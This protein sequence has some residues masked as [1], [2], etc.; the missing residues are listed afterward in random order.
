MVLTPHFWQ[1]VDNLSIES[2]WK[3]HLCYNFTWFHFVLRRLCMQGKMVKIH[4]NKASRRAKAHMVPHGVARRPT[5]P[6]HVTNP[7]ET[8]K[9]HQGAMWHVDFEGGLYQWTWWSQVGTTMDPWAHPSVQTNSTCSKQHNFIVMDKWGHIWTVEK[10]RRWNPS[11][12]RPNCA[13][14]D[15][16]KCSNRLTPSNCL[17]GASLAVDAPR[18]CIQA[19]PDAQVG[20]PTPFDAPPTFTPRHYK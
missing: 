11:V 13:S 7:W 8:K 15:V 6:C 3:Q 10:L 12:T 18:Q 14:V 2:T 9:T 1:N 20:W 16:I 17:Q 19:S 5:W 4:Q